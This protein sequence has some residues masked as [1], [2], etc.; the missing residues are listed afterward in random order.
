MRKIITVILVVLFVGLAILCYLRWDV[1]FGNLPEEPYTTANVPHR[2]LLTFGDDGANSRNVSWVSGETLQSSFL[3]LADEQDTLQV[4]ADGEVFASRAGQAAYYVARLN[5]LKPHQL[6]NYRVCTGGR[7]SDWHHFSLSDLRQTTFLYVG[8]VQDTIAGIANQLLKAAFRHHPEAQFLVCGGD[9]TERPTDAYWQETFDGLDSIGQSLPILTVTGNHDYL[10]GLI[11]SLERRFSLIHSY[12]LN[13][14]V[15]ENQVY[16]MR[17]ND[18]QLF[19]LD[20]NREFFY[21]FTQR[22]WLK[23]QLEASDAKWKIVVL[24]HPL[25]SIRSKNNNLIQRWMF[26]D[27]IRE[28]GVDLVLQAHEHAYARMTNHDEK[29]MIP[30]TPVYTV[31]HLSP[32]NY[33]IE[34]SSL[35]DKFGSG[36]RYYQKIKTSGDDLI[37]TAYDAMTQAL[38]DSVVISKSSVMDYGLN[39]PEVIEFTPVPGNK[40]DAQFA[41]RIEA[42]KQAKG[43]N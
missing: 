2:I 16:T 13:S 5:N 38:Y 37:L 32:K 30:T 42:Y 10:K 31:S 40:K 18:V 1:W 15:G 14:M 12:F 8:D 3:Q 34:F 7:Y 11:Y 24:H 4:S 39:I 26:D 27:L 21:L 22:Q 6:Y 43:I 41:E 29:L 35:F 36:S 28:Y 19:L 25:Y 17:M 23:K 20:S 33:R 9:L